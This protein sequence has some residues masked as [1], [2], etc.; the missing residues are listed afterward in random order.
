MSGSKSIQALSGI[1]SGWGLIQKGGGRNL[2]GAEE[3]HWE[4]LKRGLYREHQQLVSKKG[5][6]V[7]P[8]EK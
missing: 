7:I 5:C 8:T 4:T 2:N 6:T 3:K 1:L